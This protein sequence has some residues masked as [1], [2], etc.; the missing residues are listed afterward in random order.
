MDTTGSK[1]KDI[2]KDMFF[3]EQ[4]NDEALLNKG[5]YAIYYEYTFKPSKDV[6]L[7]SVSNGSDMHFASNLVVDKNKVE[8]FHITSPTGTSKNEFMKGETYRFWALNG[9]KVKSDEKA[10]WKNR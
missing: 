7:L 9:V 8:Q 5:I 3:N 1:P 4:S 10:K 2:F 6:R